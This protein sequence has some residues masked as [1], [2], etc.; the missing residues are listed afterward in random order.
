MQPLAAVW[1]FCEFAIKPLQKFPVPATRLPAPVT[2]GALAALKSDWIEIRQPPILIVR[3]AEIRIANAIVNR[4]V[5]AKTPFVLHVRFDGN[6]AQIR[7]VVK[8][9]L[10][11]VTLF[12]RR[13]FAKF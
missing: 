6:L 11:K 3:G 4:Y 1:T 5:L 2:C 13:K 8:A 9:G 12:P 10:A 7:G